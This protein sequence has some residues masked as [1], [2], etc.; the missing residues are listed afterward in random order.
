EEGKDAKQNPKFET[1]NP[2]RSPI[3]KFK[4]G[5]PVGLWACLYLWCGNSLISGS[6]GK[7]FPLMILSRH[8]SVCIPFSYG[9]YSL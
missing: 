8:D 1:R 6:F 2:K 7:S 9:F 3:P 4:S 5:K